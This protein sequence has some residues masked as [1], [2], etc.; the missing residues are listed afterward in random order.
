MTW[1]YETCDGYSKE[2]PFDAIIT[3][4]VYQ[5]NVDIPLLRSRCKGNLIVFCAPEDRPSEKP[6]EILF[7]QKPLSTKNFSRKCGRF[8]E[9]ICVY[10][11]WKAPFNQ[12]HWSCMTGMFTDNLHTKSVHPWQKPLSLILKLMRIYT[13]AGDVIFDPFAGYGTTLLAAKLLD[14]DAIG[15][16]IDPQWKPLVEKRMLGYE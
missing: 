12:I 15:C 1:S 10:R 3:D 16:D 2:G 4:P 13:A 8:V 7:W 11:N 6:D 9:E 14:R 5:Q